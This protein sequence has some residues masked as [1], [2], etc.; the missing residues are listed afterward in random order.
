MEH[1]D[2]GAVA[3]MLLK[4]GVRGRSDLPF[5]TKKPNHSSVPLSSQSFQNST[6][7]RDQTFKSGL[8]GDIVIPTTTVFTRVSVSEIIGQ[9]IKSY[10]LFCV[11]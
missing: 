5:E 8:M 9:S 2:A 11:L 3:D 4:V 6:P 1:V 7:T 10:I